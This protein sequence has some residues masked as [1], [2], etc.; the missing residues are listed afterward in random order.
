[1]SP[2]TVVPGGTIPVTVT[3]TPGSPGI[4]N[5]TLTVNAENVTNPTINLR[6]RG[7]QPNLTVT[8][9]LNGSFGAVRAGSSAVQ[10]LT[11]SNTGNDTLR[12]SN[13]R[14]TN[15]AFSIVGSQTSINLT[16]GESTTIGVSFAP[17]SQVTDVDVSG[18]VQIT[19]NDPNTDPFTRTVSGEGLAP[20]DVSVNQTTVEFD[21]V[22][23]ESTDTKTLSISN[24]GGVSANITS[25]Q[26]AGADATAFD[27]RGLGTV[28][29]AKSRSLLKPL[30]LSLGVQQPRLRLRLKR[31]ERS[32]QH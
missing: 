3:T 17:D 4:Q 1:V 31:K 19:T 8:S 30:Q 5:G 22:A 25:I 2:Q 28:S 24:D 16:T 6:A 7:I 9:E 14:T 12:L 15:D 23:V 26:I 29:L 27:V 11:L 18:T 20:P 32:Q 13:L 10:R 21:T